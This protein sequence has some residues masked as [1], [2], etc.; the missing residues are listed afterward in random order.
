MRRAHDAVLAGI[1]TVL[2]DDPLLTDRTKLPRRRRLLRVI[3]DS[4]L[5]LPVRSKLVRSAKNDLL[6]FTAANME[7]PKARRLRN[8]GVELVRVRRAR[9]GLDIRAVLRELGR[10][11]ILNVMIEAGT[12]VNSSAL[13]ACAVDKLIVFRTQKTAGPGGRRWATKKSAAKLQALA[14]LREQ[15]FGADQSFTGYL[16]DV[17]GDH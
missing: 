3:L 11:E 8:A 2:A 17:Y 5:R 10:R 16:R 14:G 6:V 4:R 12:A 1:G 9:N 7:S 15:R 13:L